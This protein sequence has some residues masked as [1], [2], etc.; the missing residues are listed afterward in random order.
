[1]SE[2]FD[3]VVVGGG[4]IGLACAWRA[5]QRG[6]QVCVLDAGAPGSASQAAAGMLAPASELGESAR[7]LTALNRASYAAYPAFVAELQEATGTELCFSLCGCLVV[8]LDAEAEPELEALHAL[9]QAEGLQSE[10]LD[11]A[12]CRALEPAIGSDVRAGLWTRDE[13]QVD[14]RGLVAALE[15]ACA[16]EGVSIEHGATV[17][18]AELEGER[19]V[20]V[21][22][23]TERFPAERVLLAAGARSGTE[24]WLP[25]AVRLPVEPVKGQLL[26][27]RLAEPPARLLV[28][29]ASA[30][31]VPRPD[32]R[33]VVGATSERSGF[34]ESRTAEAR[35]ELLAAATRFLPAIAAVRDPEHCVGFR[36]GTPDGLPLIGATAVDGLLVATGHYRNGILLTPI[37]ATTVEALLTGDAAPPEAAAADPARFASAS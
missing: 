32:G 8:A 15:Q 21:A 2:R 10:L 13:G 6:L 19:I 35:D 3:L 22:T 36:P 9:Q 26:R 29:S 7:R 33:V 31:V 25:A 17:E 30:Y 5:A 12:G 16:A 4:V 24:A 34:D 14:P 27:G 18:H 23:K 11:A 28:R 37:T 20:A 1:M